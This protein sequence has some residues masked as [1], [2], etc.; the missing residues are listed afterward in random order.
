MSYQQC[1]W[2]DPYPRLAFALKLLYFAPGTVQL[3]ATLELQRYLADQWDSPSAQK[4]LHEMKNR[5][6]QGKRW[7]DENQQTFETVE[8]LKNSPDFL[9]SR[10]ADTLLEILSADSF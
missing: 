1:R 2:Y 5:Q 3:K 10:V 6:N 9:K 4:A 7:Y 8:L